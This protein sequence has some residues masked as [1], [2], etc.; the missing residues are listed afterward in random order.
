VS[1]KF[2]DELIMIMFFINRYCYV[3]PDIA[4]EFS[5]FDQDPNKYIK[6]YTGTNAVTKMRRSV[7]GRLKATELLSGGKLKV[8]ITTTGTDAINISGLLV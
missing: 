5:K 4:K 6:K 8:T 2:Y 1:P 3:C 7:D